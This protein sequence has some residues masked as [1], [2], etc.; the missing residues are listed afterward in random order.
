MS[1]GGDDRQDEPTALESAGR[2]SVLARLA[3]RAVERSRDR[4]LAGQAAGGEWDWPVDGDTGLDAELLLYRLWRGAAGDSTSVSRGV[5]RLFDLADAA[6]GWS[7]APGGPFDLG[8]SVRAYLACKLAGRSADEPVLRRACERIREAGGAGAADPLTRYYLALFRQASYFHCPPLPPEMLGLFPQFVWRFDRLRAPAR[9]LLVPLS[10]VWARRPVRTWDAECGVGELY[11]E[12]E[13]RPF[14]GSATA[15]D[16]MCNRFWRWRER[17]RLTPFRGAAE[18]RA[19]VWML[20]RCVGSDGPGADLRSLIWTQIALEAAGYPDESPERRFGDERIDRLVREDGSASPCHATVL[21]TAVAVET[22]GVC[23]VSA[24]E[25]RMMAAVD[26]LLTKE[27]T[28]AGDWSSR[29]R[30]APAG[31]Y[32]ERYNESFPDVA[33]TALVLRAFGAQFGRSAGDSIGGATVVVGES[34]VE[35]DGR[36]ARRMGLIDLRSPDPF[37]VLS[38][39]RFAA[40]TDVR[41][42]LRRVHAV[43]GAGRRALDWLL[44]L[45]NDDGGWARFERG[46]E[47]PVGTAGPLP[48]ALAAFDP[49]SPGV[50]A[51]VLQTL[52]EYDWGVG[53]PAV[54]RALRFLRR[55]QLRD[56]RW[57][58]S[59]DGDALETTAKVLV[60]LRSVGVAPSDPALA[61]GWNWL[62]E[63]RLPCGG[64]GPAEPTGKGG[65]VASPVATAWG[66]LG[67]LAGADKHHPAACDGVRWLLDRQQDDGGWDETQF[68]ERGGP[69]GAPRRRR[70]DATA[71]PTAALGAW[72][73]AN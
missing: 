20:D 46:G 30:A 66:V 38:Y 8:T 3:R 69:T 13:R 53:E 16:R 12:D 60:G 50:T 9:T 63:R 70:L 29:A 73:Q 7:V 10:V 11:A 18:R 35:I 57:A 32:A 34:G 67:T 39:G 62:V 47:T 40:P 6:G 55:S 24:Q 25:P 43:A 36:L 59:I 56:G 71:A 22:L 21:D 54:D 49:S 4:L 19:I 14:D 58:G 5:D 44:A 33:T 26:W 45:Q 42:F 1:V 28:R 27:A 37:L 72:L 61:A 65:A 64:W 68:H 51:S 48:G 2:S 41:R 23:G 17:L 52:A 15:G 31:W